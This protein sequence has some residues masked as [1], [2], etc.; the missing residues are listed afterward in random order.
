[1][2]IELRKPYVI[3]RFRMLRVRVAKVSVLQD[4]SQPQSVGSSESGAS[5][6]TS[7]SS[8]VGSTLNHSPGSNTFGGS[9]TPTPP[10]CS[11]EQN[12]A[13]GDAQ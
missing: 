3:L 10:P 6:I 1:M 8:G 12:A 9:T 13:N 7:S 2:S 11:K 4:T 5:S